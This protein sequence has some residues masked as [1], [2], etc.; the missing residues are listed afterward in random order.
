[1]K[2]GANDRMEDS[3]DESMLGYI[4][5]R[6]GLQGFLCDFFDARIDARNQIVLSIRN[7][8]CEVSVR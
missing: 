4:R 1:M 7:S 3:V 2:R 5:E 6:N 8:G